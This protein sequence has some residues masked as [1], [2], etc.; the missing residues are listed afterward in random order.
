MPSPSP[1]ET[2]RGTVILMSV[3]LL[4]RDVTV[5]FREPLSRLSLTRGDLPEWFRD[6]DSRVDPV[7]GI[8]IS[9]FRTGLEFRLSP[10]RLAVRDIARG[11]FE[12]DRL[13]E[14]VISILRA[15]SPE[16]GAYGLNYKAEFPIGDQEAGV[17]LAQSLLKAELQTNHGTLIGVRVQLAYELEGVRYSLGLEPRWNDFRAASIYAA[18]NVQRERHTPDE[19]AILVAEL[20]EGM[21][22]FNTKLHAIFPDTAMEQ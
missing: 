13:P 20:S 19:K 7:E 18:L 2:T 11:E 21:S 6:A 22:W 5:V 16:I 1:L 14:L 17:F 12:E 10:D 8:H 4:E 9:S 15:V 3:Q